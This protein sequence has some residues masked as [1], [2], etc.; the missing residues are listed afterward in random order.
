MKKLFRNDTFLKI[1]SLVASILCWIYIVFVNNPSIEV[2]V[3]G[4]PITLSDHQSIKNEGYI[5]SNDINQT[6]DIKL[7]GTRKMLAG[8]NRD[9]II[10]YVD[11]SGCTG[12]NSYKLPVSVKLPYD[13]VKIVSKSIYNVTVAVDNLISRDFDIECVYTG[14][15]QS[16]AYTVN[17]TELEHSKVKVS[18]PEDIV[19]TI[20][21]AEINVNVDGASADVSGISPVVLLNSNNSVVKANSISLDE[22]EIGYQCKIYQRKT[23]NVKPNISGGTSAVNVTVTDHPTVTLIGPSAE[24]DDITEVS[25]SP[26]SYDPSSLP[27]IYSANLIIPK[28]ISAE[29]NISTVNI[30]V[31]E[32]ND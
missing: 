25:T 15:P 28:N 18:G 4:V 29:D 12:K 30:L 23:F 27:H 9:N 26:V 8:I 3:T 19:K 5:V 7:K 24:I 17:S 31:E 13:E 11:L 16:N 1:F 21:K 2:K 14:E 6:V 22:A 20:E 32:K 10:A